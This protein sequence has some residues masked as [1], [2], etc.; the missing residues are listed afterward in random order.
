MSR[1]IAHAVI[2]FV[3]GTGIYIE[4]VGHRFHYDDFHSIVENPHIRTL[5]NVGRF[6][7]DP[8]QF[9]TH[10]HNPMYRPVVLASYA[11]NHAVDGLNPR[12]YHLFNV[13][14][15]GI[16]GI[17][18]Y[19]L[20]RALTPTA[21]AFFAACL[22]AIHPINSE[23]ANYVSS[24]SEM[25]MAGFFLAS[26]IAWVRFGATGRWLWYCLALGGAGWLWAPSR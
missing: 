5:A 7:L 14:L 26:C 8:S 22:F 11:V 21:V 23:A 19:A 1:T 3:C 18:V 20:L 12:G 6:F 17:L 13:L 25:L 4:A 10:G 9:S 2:L 16:N 15:H 24:R